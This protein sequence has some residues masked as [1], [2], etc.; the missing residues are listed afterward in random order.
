MRVCDEVAGAVWHATV[1]ATRHLLAEITDALACEAGRFTCQEA[2]AVVELLN[3]HGID[4]THFA[5]EHARSDEPTDL[6]YQE[7]PP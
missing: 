1:V 6:H 5:A 7:G 3:L 4:S 2:D